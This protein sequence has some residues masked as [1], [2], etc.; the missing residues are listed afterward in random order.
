V[1]INQKAPE[2]GLENISP[3]TGETSNGVCRQ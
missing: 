1:R 2:P 3:E